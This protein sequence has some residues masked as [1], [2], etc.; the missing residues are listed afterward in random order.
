M[1]A[2]QIKNVVKEY[3]NGVQALSGL[4]LTVKQGELFSLLGQNGAGKSTLIRILTTY[5]KPTSGHI[6]MFGKD[7]EKEATTI[8]TEI[9][10]VSQQTSIDTYLSLEENM[11]FQSRLYKIPKA[12]AFDRMEKLIVAFGLEQYR[13]YPVS[14]YS[15]GV[16]RRLDIAL[17]MMTNPKLLFLDEP[18]VGMDIQSRRLMWEMINKIR[19]DFGTTIFLTT[20][21]L[22]EADNLSNTICIMK[23]GKEVIQGTPFDLRSY[24]RQDNVQIHFTNAAI[25]KQYMSKLKEH[26]GEQELYVKNTTLIV[27]THNGKNDMEKAI[28]FLLQKNIPFIG[29]EVAQPTLEDVFLRLTSKSEG[30]SL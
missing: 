1:Y 22:E 17:N 12:E 10:C 25:L 16:K 20:H 9:A 23:D 3:K 6:V 28:Y 27:H 24:L 4:N 11:L 8:R 14:S 30:N 7:I 19:N 13:K 2:I 18:T 26:F 5:L 15:G 21:Y 29:I